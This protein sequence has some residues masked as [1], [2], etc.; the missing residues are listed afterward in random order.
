MITADKL[1]RPHNQVVYSPIT[2]VEAPKINPL[3]SAQNYV[4][5]ATKLNSFSFFN[6]E[7]G[8]NHELTKL[9]YSKYY[10]MSR[11]AGRRI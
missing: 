10:R 6:W 4:H 1:S 2:T 3:V 11:M 7:K 8:A 5:A 9:R